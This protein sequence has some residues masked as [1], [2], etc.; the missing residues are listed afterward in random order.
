M[1]C[2]LPA[3]AIQRSGTARLPRRTKA[4]HSPG[5][6]ARVPLSNG[7]SALNF[8]VSPIA[9]L[10]GR[11]RRAHDPRPLLHVL[12]IGKTGGTALKHVLMQ[13]EDA[14]RYRM[15]FW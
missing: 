13:Y 11:A 7:A 4:A 5:N 10:R 2:A 1:E 3:L 14:S 15:L 6:R 9:L 8:M 12:H